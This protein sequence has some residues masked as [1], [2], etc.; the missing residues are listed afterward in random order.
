ML[1][2]SE[3]KPGSAA[4]LQLTQL[5]QEPSRTKAAALR[6][7]ATIA[8]LAQHPTLLRDAAEI[9]RARGDRLELAFTLADLSHTQRTLGDLQR[10]RMTVRRAWDLAGDCRADGLQQRLRPD[11]D[12]TTLEI[13]D[14]VDSEAFNSPSEAERRV[15]ALA[16]QGNTNRQIAE[17]LFMTI[18]TVEQHLTKVYRKLN[19]TRRADLLLKLGPRI[20]NVA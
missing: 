12:E 15:A 18:S 11:I 8:P 6:V 3:R 5:G 17:K 20:G 16:A 14:D 19:V 4:E 9:L 2:G 1:W 13:A 7:L 10:A